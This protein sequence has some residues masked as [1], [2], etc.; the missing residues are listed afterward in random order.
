M[1][2]DKEVDD[3]LK[4]GL[5]LRSLIKFIFN[6]GELAGITACQK[7]IGGKDVEDRPLKQ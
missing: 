2:T 3:Y 7:I 4:I 6:E 5:P 1:L